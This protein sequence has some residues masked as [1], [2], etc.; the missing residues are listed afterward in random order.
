[1]NMRIAPRLAIISL[2]CMASTAVLAHKDA[3]PDDY[4]SHNQTTRC[5]EPGNITDLRQKL[6]EYNATRVQVSE[7]LYTMVESYKLNGKVREG[8]LGFA[9]LFEKMGN[10]LPQPDPD[11]DEFRNFDFKLGL[12][13]AAVVFYLNTSDESLT[14]QFQRDQQNPNSALGSYLAELD[15]SRDAYMSELE[16]SHSPDQTGSCS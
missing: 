13:L 7:V 16:H 4:P 11:S 3:V 15:L 9:E 1:M 10:E 6:N 5:T 2:C 12:S 14:Q 8:L